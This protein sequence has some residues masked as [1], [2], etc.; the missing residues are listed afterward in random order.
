MTKWAVELSE[1]DI[2]YIP[3]AS[4][5]GHAV[6]K[7]VVEFSELDVE[8]ARMMEEREMKTFQ[9]RLYLYGSSNTHGSG[10]GIMVSTP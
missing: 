7:F 10:V 4:P 3:K 1:F 6:T 8:V 9:W 2:K 5:K